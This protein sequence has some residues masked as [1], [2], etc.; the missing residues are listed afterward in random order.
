M[1]KIVQGSKDHNA[2]LLVFLSAAILATVMAALLAGC[3]ATDKSAEEASGALPCPVIID[4]ESWRTFDDIAITNY[5]PHP[6]IKAPVA[7]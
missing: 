6:H 4:T 1:R 3:Q 5:D 2:R 7:V